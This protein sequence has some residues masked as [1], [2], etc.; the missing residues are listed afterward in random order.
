[1][2]RR[3][4]TTTLP[5]RPRRPG[6][7][8]EP[9]RAKRSGGDAEPG[10]ARRPGG[11]AEP[12]RPERPGQVPVA[13]RAGRPSG[14]AGARRDGAGAAVRQREEQPR[15]VVAPARA[16]PGSP[17]R[18]PA[19]PAGQTAA[20]PESRTRFVFLVLGL[21]GGGL[22]CLLLINTVLATGA[23]RITALQ[24][25]NAALSQQSQQ[26]QA[27]IAAER[28]PAVLAQRARKLGMVSPP[29]T[30][31]LDLSKGRVISQPTRV[32]GVIVYPPG[33]TP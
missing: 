14:A 11:F 30:H 32:P 21:L 4:D 16:H 8:P 29:L 18:P 17:G 15:P 33:Y 28:S 22:I 1:M 20:A 19:R 9:G 24:K 23:L 25:S 7:L 6:G 27:Q 13:A 3:G 5:G 26:L 2:N 10:R 12:G 31:F